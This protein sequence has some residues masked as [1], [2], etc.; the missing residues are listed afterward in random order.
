[1]DAHAIPQYLGSRWRAWLVHNGLGM[2]YVVLLGVLAWWLQ[3]VETQGLGHAVLDALVLALLLGILWRHVLGVPACARPGILFTGK[4]VLEVAV[5]LLGTAID[6]PALLRAGPWLLLAVGIVVVVGIVAGSLIGRALGLSANLATLIAVGS[7]ICGNSAMAAIAP[8]IAAT[9]EEVASAMAA[10]AVMGV[11]VVLLL[12][13]LIPLLGFTLY[14]Y[15]VLAG[16]AVYAVPQV[17][18]ATLPVSA[19]SGHIGTLV[20]LVRVLLLGPVLLVFSLR[21]RT[22]CAT[23]HIALGRVLPW[24]ILGFLGL[25]TA[26][27]TGVLPGMVVEP[28]RELSR[29]LTIA[30]MAALGL[31]V[32]LQAVRRVGA[33]V[34]ATVVL[35]LL[36]L[37][38]LST[39]FIRGFGIH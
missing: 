32:P 6:L 31:E 27:S 34:I 28:L 17:L 30:A 26:R 16:M 36:V 13:L 9:A 7:A 18:A 19:V 11:V 20:K 35:S 2:T 14:Q 5:A 37:I 8:V 33:A 4:Y 12:P 39:V 29:W 22:A 38:A 15:G 10:T 21:Q 25:A 3:V 1:M 24:F 23:R